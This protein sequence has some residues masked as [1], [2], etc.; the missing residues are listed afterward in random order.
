MIRIFFPSKAYNLITNMYIVPGIL[1]VDDAVFY[2]ELKVSYEDLSR[3]LK[4]VGCG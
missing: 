3:I 2:K 4:L 1:S